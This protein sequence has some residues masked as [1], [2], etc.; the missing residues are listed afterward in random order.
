MKIKKKMIEN[1]FN[2]IN[3]AFN[4]KYCVMIL[5]I[6]ADSTIDISM[7]RVSANF[8]FSVSHAFSLLHF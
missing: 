5:K 7:L 8:N 2:D 3:T 1:D 4:I 6:K